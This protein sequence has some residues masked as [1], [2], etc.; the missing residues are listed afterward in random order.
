MT[1]TVITFYSYKG[2]VGRSFTLANTAVLLARWGYRVLAVDWDLE[3]PGLHLYFRPH[4]SQMPAG[5][6]VD[7]A[8]EFIQ[9]VETPTE[10][11][12]RV[13]VQGGVLD[14]LAAG[15]VV[16]D[17]LDPASAYRMGED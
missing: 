6:V 5:G 16:G 12:V 4:L 10:H 13:D 15:K 11:T 2:G 1:G 17:K 7:L 8:H 14:L 9:R 3:A